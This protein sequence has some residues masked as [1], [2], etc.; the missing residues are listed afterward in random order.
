MVL[1]HGTQFTDIAHAFG[2][3]YYLKNDCN[4]FKLSNN[5]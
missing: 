2:L 1:Y 3:F 4:T 5:C